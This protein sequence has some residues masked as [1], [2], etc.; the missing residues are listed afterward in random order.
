M[1]INNEAT[2]RNAKARKVVKTHNL[3]LTLAASLTKEGARATI[4]ARLRSG[5]LTSTA[6]AKALAHNARRAIEA[7]G[8]IPAHFAG[9]V[10]FGKG[11]DAL[12]IDADT[13]R[14]LNRMIKAC[15]VIKESMTEEDARAAAE[16]AAAIIL[17]QQEAEKEAEKAD[18]EKEAATV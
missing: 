8:P 5:K 1:T 7:L 17:A 18:A 10:Y 4:G 9:A 11:L 12:A 6:M 14:T 15:D 16:E 2:D 13:A 3:V